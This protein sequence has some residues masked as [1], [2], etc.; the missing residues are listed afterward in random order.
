MNE[1]AKLKEDLVK[2]EEKMVELSVHVVEHQAT[3]QNLSCENN[4]LNTRLDKITKQNY[5]GKGKESTIQFQ[6]EEELI[7]TKANMMLH[8]KET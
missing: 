1:K 3:L 5:K 7:Q 4:V 6:L 2:Y 8:F